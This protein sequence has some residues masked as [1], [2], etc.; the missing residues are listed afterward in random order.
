[1][2]LQDRSGRTTCIR[3]R[4]LESKK[5]II[6]DSL[7][8][9]LREAVRRLEEAARS[10]SPDLVYENAAALGSQKKFDHLRL[11][12]DRYGEEIFIFL[13]TEGPVHDMLDEDGVLGFNTGMLLMADNPAGL[14]YLM[15]GDVPRQLLYVQA[16]KEHGARRHDAHSVSYFG[17]D[18]VSPDTYKP[19]VPLERDLDREVRRRA[20][21]PS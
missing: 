19:P 21:C 14:A 4:P 15:E 9:G 8:Q 18:P 17:A 20:R 13:E 2:R 7:H 12:V 3:P 10:T 1:M 6:N 11:L 16:V 5:K